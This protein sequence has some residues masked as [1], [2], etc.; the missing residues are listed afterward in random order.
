MLHSTFQGQCVFPRQRSSGEVRIKLVTKLTQLISLLVFPILKKRRLFRR[1]ASSLSVCLYYYFH[2]Y[3]GEKKIHQK[4]LPSGLSSGRKTFN[5][6]K[7]Q[8]A[9]FFSLP[10]DQIF[11][12][13]SSFPVF[14]FSLIQIFKTLYTY[15]Q[16]TDRSN[17]S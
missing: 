9:I 7:N 13:F 2:N 17:F 11:F 15:L 4:K 10:P 8:T 6:F 16:S 3:G 12:F 5:I 14:K 1:K